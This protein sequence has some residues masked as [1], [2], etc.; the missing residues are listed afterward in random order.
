MQRI[1]FRKE[2]ILQVGNKDDCASDS[3]NGELAAKILDEYMQEFP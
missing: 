1:R 3:E 2:V